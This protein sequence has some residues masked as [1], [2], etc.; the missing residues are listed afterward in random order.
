MTAFAIR[1]LPCSYLRI[2]I[3][4]RLLTQPWLRVPRGWCLGFVSLLRCDK[5][6]K[7][8]VPV[9]GRRSGA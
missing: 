1:H 9:V 6:P 4:S 3:L 7:L 8:F 2:I 5:W